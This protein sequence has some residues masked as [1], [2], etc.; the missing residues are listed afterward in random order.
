MAKPSKGSPKR[1]K[2]QRKSQRPTKAQKARSQA[3]KKGWATRRKAAAQRSRRAK[4]GWATR[5]EREKQGRETEILKSKEPVI[6]VLYDGHAEDPP[7]EHFWSNIRH[8]AGNSIT[9][10]LLKIPATDGVLTVTF[11]E[12]DADRLSQAIEEGE[13]PEEFGEGEEKER[14]WATEIDPEA[15]WKE[16]FDNAREELPL[17]PQGKTDG[18]KALLVSKIVVAYVP[19]QISTD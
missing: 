12:T 14:Q 17:T 13:E 5:R 9:N 11:V 2:K 8:L 6:K 10:Q 4:R 15:F 3:A 16:Y 1:Q 7:T 19:G 18:T